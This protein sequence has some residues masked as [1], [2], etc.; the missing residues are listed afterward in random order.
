MSNANPRTHGKDTVV[1]AICLASLAMSIWMASTS[2]GRH[3]IYDPK[4]ATAA[5]A[6]TTE[7]AQPAEAP[8]PTTSAR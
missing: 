1:L 5:S 6:A 2:W 3:D 8:L 7:A 4:I